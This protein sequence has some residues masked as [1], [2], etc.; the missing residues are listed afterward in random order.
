M[1]GH[2][3]DPEARLMT[4]SRPTALT[5]PVALAVCVALL[6]AGCGP[7]PSP[8]PPATATG[9]AAT[10]TV[11]IE[12]P[13]VVSVA[14]FIDEQTLP[15]LDEQIVAFEAANPDVRVELLAVNREASR[16]QEQFAESLAA[17]DGTV[18]V[19]LISPHWLAGYEAP[20]WL[21]PLDGYAADARLDLGT[22]LPA[23]I[24]AS[25][26]EDRL[27]ALPWSTDGGLLYYRR[28]ILEGRGYQPPATWSEL[29]TL[30]LELKGNGGPAHGFV[31]QGDAYDGLT[32]NTLEQVWAEG[33]EAVDAGGRASF[34]SLETR[35]ALERM[36][37]FVSEGVSPATVAGHQEAAALASFRSG[38]AVFMRNWFY[39]W[40]R[41]Q[42]PGSPTAGQA[43]IAPLPASCLSGQ[44][45]V[46]SASSMVPQEAFRFMAFLVAPEQQA[47]LAAGG[48]LL[49]ALAAPYQD[50]DMLARN[51]I[52]GEVYPALLAARPRPQVADYPRLS[53]A[54]YTEVNGLLEGSQD[55]AA[56]ARNVQARLEE[57]LGE[58]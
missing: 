18:D 1:S 36:A 16:R 33:G 30:G 19:Y 8:A 23:P 44:S 10:V 47:Q 2:A 17:G 39:A 25:R 31:W 22:F 49:P 27:M 15:L 3:P 56:T 9:P 48:L 43:G 32:C 45:L 14:G 26:V 46:L 11:P 5:G 53:E 20:G 13:V 24:Q 40:A 4:N 21:L 58:E 6:L 7:S 52:L 42:E 29:E 38:E 34:D 12:M 28:D 50:P 54:I 51:P 37:R 41:L 35:T 57:V 55:P